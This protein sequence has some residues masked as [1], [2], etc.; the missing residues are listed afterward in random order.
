MGSNR[1]C[2]Q[3]L[4][5]LPHVIQK[6]ITSNYKGDCGSFAKA[7][8]DVVRPCFVMFVFIKIKRNIFLVAPSWECMPI[9]GF[10]YA[11]RFILADRL[12]CFIAAPGLYSD[13]RS[14]CSLLYCKTQFLPPV[15]DC[16]RQFGSTL[17][18]PW[19]IAF[20]F[21]NVCDMLLYGHYITMRVLC[22]AIFQ[23]LKVLY[24]YSHHVGASFI[25]LAPTFS[26]VRAPRSCRCSLFRFEP[27]C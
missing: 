17:D 8:T 14:G 10:I 24:R 11:L 1:H 19:L 9:Q 23:N 21:L 4:Q 13:S 7:I 25:S 2:G 5:I 26:K 20:S 6:N 3:F 18:Y 22:Q 15:S 12:S 16:F 27:A